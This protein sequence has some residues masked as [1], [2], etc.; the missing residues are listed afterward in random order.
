[1]H[2][3][4]R[5]YLLH[6]LLLFK[7]LKYTIINILKCKKKKRTFLCPL[8]EDHILIIHQRGFRASFDEPK[9]IKF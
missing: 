7:C 3:V 4:R 8:A 9:V 2:A 5:G 1:M 6:Y